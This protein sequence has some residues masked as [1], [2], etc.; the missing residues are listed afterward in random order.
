MILDWKNSPDHAKQYD[1][2]DAATF[3]PLPMEPPW[4]DVFYADDSRGLLRF[5]KLDA[6]GAF[7]FVN[8]AEPDRPVFMRMQRRDSQGQWVDLEYET[9]WGEVRRGILIVRKPS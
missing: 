8:P 7:Y 4:R 5:Y 6:E 1:I 3:Q 2:L 9:A